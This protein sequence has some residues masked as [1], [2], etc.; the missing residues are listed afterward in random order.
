[1]IHASRLL[2]TVAPGALAL[3]LVACQAT[4][5]TQTQ[6]MPLE[7]EFE[8]VALEHADSAALAATLSNLFKGSSLQV[9]PDVR[10]NAL[11]VGGVSSE[12]GQARTIIGKLDVD[13]ASTTPPR[14]V[15][16]ILLENALADDVRDSIRGVVD[17]RS[18][19]ISID[20]RRNAL[21]VSASPASMQRIKELVVELDRKQ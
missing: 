21:L 14:T 12:V 18:S 8:V 1:M 10:T 19:Q 4:T 6:S 3:A 15:E 17:R 2:R 13:V 16:V 9:T 7:R 11:L 5:E 20:E